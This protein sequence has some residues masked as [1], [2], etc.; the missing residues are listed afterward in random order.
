VDFSLGGGAQGRNVLK[1][2]LSLFVNVVD[3][4]RLSVFQPGVTELPIHVAP[5][6]RGDEC[7][8]IRRIGHLSS[9]EMLVKITAS[10]Q[11]DASIRAPCELPIHVR[12]N[13]QS[14]TALDH[15]MS[16]LG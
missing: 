13:L 7:I 10:H 14:P 2:Q 12:V 1:G 6:S 8:H 11:L 4:H 16:M 5:V 15:L 3:P 9:P